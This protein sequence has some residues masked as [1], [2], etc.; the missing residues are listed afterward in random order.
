MT[1]RHEADEPGYSDEEAQRRFQALIRA[2]LN[3][4]PLHMKD[5]PRKRPEAKRRPDEPTSPHHAEH[6]DAAERAK[7]A[8]R[9]AGERA[10]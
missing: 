8:M 10:C 4:P 9:E 6:D 3:T 2:A 7:T 5:I 1:T